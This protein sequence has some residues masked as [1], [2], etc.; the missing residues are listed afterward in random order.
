MFSEYKRHPEKYVQM[1]FDANHEEHTACL[2]SCDYLDLNFVPPRFPIILTTDI[3]LGKTAPSDVVLSDYSPYPIVVLVEKLDD[4]TCKKLST[5]PDCPVYW[6]VVSKENEC[7]FDCYQRAYKEMS[8]VCLLFPL[9]CI[10]AVDT[11]DSKRKIQAI[12][13]IKHLEQLILKLQME[14]NWRN[15][16]IDTPP[17]YA[18]PPDSTP[19]KIWQLHLSENQTYGVY[20]PLLLFR[21]FR[22]EI[23]KLL[24][25][26]VHKLFTVAHFYQPQRGTDNLDQMIQLIQKTGFGDPPVSRVKNGVKEIQMQIKGLPDPQNNFPLTAQ[27]QWMYFGYQFNSKIRWQKQND[28]DIFKETISAL[29]TCLIIIDIQVDFSKNSNLKNIL[30]DAQKNGSMIWVC[31]HDKI[32]SFPLSSTT[33]I[34]ISSYANPDGNIFFK[35]KIDSSSNSFSF[36]KY[37]TVQL[38]KEPITP[39]G[40]YGDIIPKVKQLTACGKTEQEIALECNIR[41][42]YTLRQIKRENN[43]RK[44]KPVKTKRRQGLDAQIWQMYKEYKEAYIHAQNTQQLPDTEKSPL[45]KLHDSFVKL[46]WVELTQPQIIEIAHKLKVAPSY[47]KKRLLILIERDYMKSRESHSDPVE[48]ESEAVSRKGKKACR[49]RKDTKNI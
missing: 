45:E 12:R 23:T 40:K 43:I 4:D 39:H 46:P 11:I 30:L 32:P 29:R 37:I 18:M 31:Y 25:S 5:R 41:K 20:F 6:L 21:Y 49:K 47:I 17:A 16:A 14:L 27:H 1:W 22:F 38:E 33:N 24:M 3:N 9:R 26:S 28:L 13:S 48:P 8:Q 19:G 2:T 44:N 35:A 34:D 36:P 7:A 15:F 42:I 10:I